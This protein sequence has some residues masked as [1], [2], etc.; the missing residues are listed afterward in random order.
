MTDRFRVVSLIC[1]SLVAA[2]GIVA[3][4]GWV[5]GIPFLAS[6][7]SRHDTGGRRLSVKGNLTVES[8]A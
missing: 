5:L 2:I 3:L 8:P 4:L 7:F 1:A 6:L